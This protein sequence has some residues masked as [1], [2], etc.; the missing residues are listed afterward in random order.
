MDRIVSFAV[1]CALAA[2]AA[3]ESRNTS[4]ENPRGARP[5]DSGIAVHASTPQD[6]VHATSY[7]GLRYGSLPAGFTYRAGSAIPR[8]NGGA[9]FVLS[10]VATPRGTM[11]WLESLDGRERLV[12]AELRVPPLAADERFLTGSCDLDG[13]LDP[14]IVAIVVGD[15]SAKRFT[16][17]RQAW[18]ANADAERFEVLPVAGIVCEEPGS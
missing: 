3:C 15:S 2:G 6:F 14:H 4:D 12:R 10:Q 9:R 16:N 17:V 13:R 11:L 5:S 18:R 1:C 8:T 7:V